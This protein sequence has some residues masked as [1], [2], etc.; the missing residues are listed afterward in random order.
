MSDNPNTKDVFKNFAITKLLTNPA[1]SDEQIY[2]MAKNRNINISKEQ[3]F[4]ILKHVRNRYSKEY[5][6]EKSQS[7]K[8]KFITYAENKI[9]ENP[10]ISANKII[11]DAKKQGISIR[12]QEALYIVKDL[13]RNYRKGKTWRLPEKE[14]KG[15]YFGRVY[16]DFIDRSGEENAY[17]MA[18]HEQEYIKSV[19]RELYELEREFY[20]RYDVQQLIKLLEVIYVRKGFHFE[21]LYKRDLTKEYR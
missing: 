12:R 7:R 17:W 2:L 15:H 9:K 5:I 18:T 13:K 20:Y 16:V 1:L 6:K 4:E 19:Q 8:D 10:S 14:I 21:E 11:E 3:A